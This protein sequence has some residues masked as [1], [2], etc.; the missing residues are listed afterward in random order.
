MLS[1]LSGNHLRGAPPSPRQGISRRTENAHR[2]VLRVHSIPE[3]ARICAKA[4]AIIARSETVG[5]QDEATSMDPTRSCTVAQ[6]SPHS[7]SA[8]RQIS[9]HAINTNSE[10]NCLKRLN[11]LDKV[12][13][14]ANVLIWII[15]RLLVHTINHPDQLRQIYRPAFLLCHNVALNVLKSGGDPLTFVAERQYSWHMATGLPIKISRPLSS[16]SITEY[17]EVL[18]R[19]CR[20]NKISHALS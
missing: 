2:S 3:I 18:S 11:G 5:S 20:T 4:T 13:F 19:S 15:D 7:S 6:R 12:N 10:Y 9:V 1:S 14:K 8:Q 16:R 17:L